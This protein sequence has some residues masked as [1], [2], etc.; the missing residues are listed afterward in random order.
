MYYRI[1]KKLLLL[2]VFLFSLGLS[3]YSDNEKLPGTK[4]LKDLNQQVTE[5]LDQEPEKA[6]TLANEALKLA[7]ETG[8]KADKAYALKNL[9]NVHYYI[10]NYRQSLEYF[11]QALTIYKQIEDKDGIGS[12]LNNSGLILELQGDY[13]G[14]LKRYIEASTIFS[15]ISN[16]KKLALSYT[17]I[18]NVYYTLG[19]YDKSLDYLSQALRIQ[20]KSGDSLGLSKS[21]NNIGNIYLSVGDQK[22]AFDFY[23]KAEL[24][25]KSMNNLK[26]LAISYNNLGTALQGQG[27]IKEALEYNRLSIEISRR[28][29]DQAGIISS[30]TNI[31]NIYLAEGDLSQALINYKEALRLS[32]DNEDRYQHASILSNLASLRIKQNELDEAISLLNE[33]LKFAEKA[34]SDVLL[35]EIYANL[36]EAWQQKGDYKRAFDFLTKHKKNVDSIYNLESAER[37]NRLRVSFESE[38]TE[39]DNQLLRQQNIFSQLALKRQQTIRN[40]LI[41]ISVIIIVF[42]TFLLSLYQSKKRKN[43][44]LAERTNQIIQQK[45]ELD[46]LYKEQFKQNETKNKFFSIV[47]HDLKSPFQSILGFSEL[48]S[49]EYDYLTE[50]QR[51]EAATNI[52][53]VSNDTFRLI[54]NLLEWGRTQTGAVRAVFKTF[55]VRDLALDTLPLFQTQLKKKDIQ[56]TY[57]LPPLLQAWADP[58][59]IMTVLRNLLS[60]AIKF[61]PVG[62][63]I[64]LSASQSDEMVRF[65]VKDTGTGMSPDILE[66]LFTFD[67]KVQRAGTMGERGTGLGLALCLEFM[68]LNHGII[69][70]E[71]EPGKGSTFTMIMQPVSRR[72]RD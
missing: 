66:R 69:K 10:A 17:N 40:L 34:G 58:D 38:E 29:N 41:A 27:K 5:L 63:N 56:L 16:E 55:I 54:E 32:N 62:G 2:I 47:A 7:N 65:S 18:G 1:P 53:N 49:S 30:L 57:D 28:I 39:R 35:L 15:N 67:P 22:L 26:S 72:P 11:E 24:I 48:L 9:G 25:N 20:E 13:S 42:T 64:H 68:E 4:K 70:V 14:A 3:G 51:R 12:T 8:N 45:D 19:R 52:L 50:T 36:S 43:E 59:M 37:L 23:H 33:S 61:T 21:Y 60:N 44:L 71:S 31:G 46:K 6:L